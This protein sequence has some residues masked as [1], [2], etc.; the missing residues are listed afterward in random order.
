MRLARERSGCSAR[1]GTPMR[2]GVLV[3]RT[4]AALG[5]LGMGLL[6]VVLLGAL[7][8]GGS[9]E[10][11]A[12]RAVAGGV[13]TL[14]DAPPAP[15][16]A[17]PAADAAEPAAR[18]AGTAPPGPAGIG[19][20]RPGA[21]RAHELRRLR[22]SRTV[23]GALRRAWLARR[24]D[25]G[26]LAGYRG[27]WARATAAARR[28]TGPRGTEQR[29]VV[30]MA[31]RLAARK[32]LGSS[33]L[34]AVFLA[35]RRN[36]D[37]WPERAA[38]RPR[39]R[40]AFGRDPVVFQYEPG[41]GL[42]LHWLGTWGRANA[43]AAYCLDHVRRC[44]ERA[45][46]FE[47]RRLTALASRRGG[48]AAWE[49]FHAF[50]G[51]SAPWV[52][53]MTQGTA[54]QALARGRRALH[55]PALGTAARRALGAFERRPPAGVA[56]R[57]RGGHHY[58][59]YSFAPG[60]RILNGDLQAVTGLHDMAVLT[61]SRRARRLYRSGERAARR[62]V[63]GYD[64]GA[65]SLYSAD[66]RESTLGYHRLVDGFLR[67]LC[68]RTR[69]GAY[70]GA[71]RRF[72]RYEREPTRIALRPT[73]RR[74]AGRVVPLAFTLSKQSWVTLEVRGARGLALRRVL[75]LT[76]GLHVVPWRPS[77]RGGYRL[78]VAAQ[79]VSGP[80]GVRADGLR[81]LAAPR[82]R[83]ERRARAARRARALRRARVA[84]TKAAERRREARRDGD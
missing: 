1:P 78:R 79:G 55:D 61:G 33:R 82:S 63:A 30:L 80:L 15:P 81:V 59:M 42:V 17:P 6:L 65:W 35:L 19:Q 51:G 60:L 68:R 71:A 70:C 20:A 3:R 31:M 74:R 83:A 11:P 69:R 29:A 84:A 2:G 39:Q 40:F 14:A 8:G 27:T 57:V 67:N 77:R 12:A 47:L 45:L 76:R 13:T 64:T 32:E 36:T 56:V 26:T 50:G 46:R 43:R 62:A 16:L 38:P 18:A 24:L 53:G 25:A 34:P 73:G 52:S 7:S 4:S 58:L 54:V 21:W 22:R 72:T 49:S 5:A 37:F 66:G 48:Y 23:P 10:R 41:Q 44:P 75:H 9:R 28:L